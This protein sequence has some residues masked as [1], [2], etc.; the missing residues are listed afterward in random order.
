MKVFQHSNTADTETVFK[1]G[2]RVVMEFHHA[3]QEWTGVWVSSEP[4]AWSER[5][6]LNSA[7][8]VF[9]IEIPEESIAEFEWVEE[10]KM[11]REWLIPA[12]LIN[13]YGIPVVMDDY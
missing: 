1:D 2:F 10:G 5:Q 11:I 8:T 7:N 6:Y 12:K 13:S 9:T 4:L 3:G